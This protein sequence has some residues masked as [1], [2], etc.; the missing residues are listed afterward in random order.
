LLLAQ[1]KLAILQDMVGIFARSQE[2]AERRL[3][4]GDISKIEAARIR[5]DGLRAANDA[6]QADTDLT[7]ARHALAALLGAEAQAS[8]IKAVDAWPDPGMPAAL[9][10]LDA[11]IALRPDVRAAE[12]RLR[13]SEAG[14]RLALSA[15][16]RDVTVGMQYKHFPVNPEFGTGSG[17]T[18]GVTVSVPLFIR[19]EYQGEIR[20]AEIERSAAVDALEKVRASARSD[21]DRAWSELTQAGA[22][23]ARFQGRLLEDARTAAEGVEF[24]Y[25][26]G[27]VGVADL[28]DAR[29][30]FRATQIDASAARNDYAKA[31][32]AWQLGI[33]DEPY[34]GAD[35]VSSDSVKDS[36]L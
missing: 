9:I 14:L 4:L 23:V 20:K 27:A 15:T 16:T 19:H 30:T 22:R 31:L 32:A 26:Q 36:A 13:A 35:T 8:A 34:G 28:L 5:V 29:R 1:E 25:R 3:G 18:Y 24:A 2:V 33:G 7:R 12:A 11:A 6:G 21:L 10:E 17:S